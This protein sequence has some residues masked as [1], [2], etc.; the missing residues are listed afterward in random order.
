MNKDSEADD[1]PLVES[2]QAFFM[3]N[4]LLLLCA[5]PNQDHGPW[6]PMALY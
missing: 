2:R 4:A 3:P 5:E 1:T 6:R